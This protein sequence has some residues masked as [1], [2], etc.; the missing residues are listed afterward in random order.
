MPGPIKF[1]QTQWSRL[2]A[3][4][5]SGTVLNDVLG[6]YR[7]PILRFVEAQGYSAEDAEELVQEV[8]KRIWA[9][10]VLSRAD[11]R[12]GRFRSF[13]LG[14][15]RNVLKDHEK[16]MMAEKRGGRVKTFSLDVPIG[17][18]RGTG[19]VDAIPAA[20]HDGV[21]DRAWLEWL[22]KE[23]LERLRRRCEKRGQ[24]YYGLLKRQLDEDPPLSR[25]AEETGRST[26][27]V[28]QII[29]R[30]RDMLGEIITDFIMGYCS[31]PEEYEEEIAYFGR[32]LSRQKRSGYA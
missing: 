28:K 23:G 1:A 11:R 17:P 6:S 14:L 10:G 24:P 9:D 25:L 12:K 31:T 2:A 18:D 8:L 7:T 3:A 4:L 29:K 16:R 22:V 32:R 19:W 5:K 27:D 15:T 20:S 13:L 21:F 30:A 26:D